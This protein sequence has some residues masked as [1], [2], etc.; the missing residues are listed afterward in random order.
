[1]LKGRIVQPSRKLLQTKRDG[2]NCGG[3][4]NTSFCGFSAVET[5]QISGMSITILPAT[6][7]T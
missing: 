3:K 4:V 2:I 1:V 5:I 6:S 7:N